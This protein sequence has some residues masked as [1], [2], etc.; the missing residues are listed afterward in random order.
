MTA[1]RERLPGDGVP[2]EALVWGDGPRVALLLH[3]FPDDPGSWAEVAEGLASDGLRVVA[4]WLRG[5]GPNER[6][7][8]G[9]YGL[10]AVARDAVA[11]AAGGDVLLVGHDWGRR[12]PTPPRPWRRRGSGP[13]SACR[14]PRCGRSCPAS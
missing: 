1:R 4:P 9:G 5:Y 13:W 8:P 12:S 7:A 11:L 2:L 14:F 10:E 6:P 3:G